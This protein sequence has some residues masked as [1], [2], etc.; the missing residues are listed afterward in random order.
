MYNNIYVCMYIYTLKYVFA[1]KHLY[2][3]L[4]VIS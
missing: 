2:L 1:E 3:N 4:F